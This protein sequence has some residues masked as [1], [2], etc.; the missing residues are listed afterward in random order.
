MKTH[1]Y[2]VV[3]YITNESETNIIAILTLSA[4][5][6]WCSLLYEWE[7]ACSVHLTKMLMIELL[8]LLS[9]QSLPW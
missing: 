4:W 6:F 1:G 5:Y 2:S 3:R 7:F 9:W 8:M